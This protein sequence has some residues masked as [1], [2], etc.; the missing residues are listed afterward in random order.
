VTDASIADLYERSRELARAGRR[1]L[2]GLTGPPGVGK[3]TVA[4]AIAEACDGAATVV[5][6]DG[7]HLADCELARL[8]R[9]ARKGAADT[10]DAAGF[11]HLLRRLRN[12]EELVY[13]PVF[14][15][16]QELAM[17][18][19]LPIPSGLPLVIVE[20]NYLLADGPFAPVRDL[21]DECWFLDLDPVERRQRLIARHVRH[22]RTPSAAE[23]W[24]EQTDEAN[25]AIV[26]RTRRRADR[27]LRL[28]A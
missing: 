1:T 28:Q 20:G 12:D 3:S 5:G 21:L 10:F 13:A 2:L 7:F 17:A 27:V 15:R 23:A 24:V 6:M 18:G 11:V 19:A 14:V 22:G 8:G 4:R 25:A 16:E 26:D 9:S